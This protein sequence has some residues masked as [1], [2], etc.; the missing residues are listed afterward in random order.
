MLVMGSDQSIEA[1]TII[2]ITKWP[3]K[4]VPTP[5]RRDESGDTPRV[6]CDPGKRVVSILVS[7]KLPMT[8]YPQDY[9]GKLHMTRMDIGADGKKGYPGRTYKFY[10]GPVVYPFGHGLC[11]SKFSHAIAKAPTSLS[12]PLDGQQTTTS[13]NTS[14]LLLDS[15]VRVTHG[16]CRGILINI[17]VDVKNTGKVDGSQTLLVFAN[18]SN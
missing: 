15:T 3:I 17:H 1:D 8:W 6:A 5:L 18:R 4:R 12:V 16:K 10:K 7:G 14:T 9:V 2:I 13:R 11:Y